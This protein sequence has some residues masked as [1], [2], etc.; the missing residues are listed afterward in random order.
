MLFESDEEHREN[1]R[2]FA[3]NKAI[4]IRKNAST[5][6]INKLLCDA[7]GIYEFVENY[8]KNTILRRLVETQK[9]GD[10]KPKG[11]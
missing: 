6:D 2:V 1:L 4:E 3:I 8:E 7:A 10:K 5:T 11:K 9:Y